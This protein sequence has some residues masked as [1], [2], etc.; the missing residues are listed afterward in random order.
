LV[1]AVTAVLALEVLELVTPELLVALRFLLEGLLHGLTL[2]FVVVAVAVVG[3][4]QSMPYMQGLIKMETQSI[5]TT[6][7]V[8]VVVV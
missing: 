3:E 2:A 6:A 5:T 7:V 4:L 8:A 1:L